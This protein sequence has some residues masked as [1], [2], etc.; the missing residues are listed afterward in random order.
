VLRIGYGGRERER[1][2]IKIM[3]SEI[4]YWCWVMQVEYDE[5]YKLHVE[6]T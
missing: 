5:V 2:R 1:V 3:F 4:K 6:N